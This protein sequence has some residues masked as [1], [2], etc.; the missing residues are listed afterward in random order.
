LKEV[1][2]D[3]SLRRT[4]LGRCDGSLGKE[5]EH[6]KPQVI[7]SIYFPAFPHSLTLTFKAIIYVFSDDRVVK[8]SSTTFQATAITAFT[9]AGNPHIS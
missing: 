9:T 4:R 7:S 2:L 5:K 3:Y 6:G 1:A 8:L